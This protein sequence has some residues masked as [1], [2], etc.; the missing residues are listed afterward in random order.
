MTK[1]FRVCFI[2]MLLLLVTGCET[3]TAYV[4]WWVNETELQN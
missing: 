4:P 2:T 1:K 3:N